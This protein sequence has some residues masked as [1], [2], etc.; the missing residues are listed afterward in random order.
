MMNMAFCDFPKKVILATDGSKNSLDAAKKTLELAKTS[1]AEVTL[2]HV[3]PQVRQLESVSLPTDYEQYQGGP[4][5]VIPSSM[6]MGLGE[7]VSMEKDT[8]RHKTAKKIIES[9][10]MIFK[11]SNIKINK[12]ILE[13]NVAQQIIKLANES[14]CDLVVVGATGHGSAGEFLLGST[15]EKIARFSKCPV[16]IVR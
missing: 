9:T 4:S 12:K 6:Q 15:A 14:G 13:G 3:I 1:G 11:D 2:V 10:E 7:V 16:M 5:T 8:D